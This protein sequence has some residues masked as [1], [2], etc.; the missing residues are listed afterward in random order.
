[1]L[2]QHGH[3]GLGG[4][5]DERRSHIVLRIE[6]QMHMHAGVV[7]HAS[8]SVLAVGAGGVIALLGNLPAHGIPDLVQVAQGRT[9]HLLG[10]APDLQL[11]LAHIDSRRHGASLAHDVAAGREAMLAQVC[12]TSLRSAVLICSTA[13]VLR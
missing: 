11:T 4:H 1:M 9:K 7:R 8:G 3:A 12:M 2:A 5:V 13:P 6:R 10:I